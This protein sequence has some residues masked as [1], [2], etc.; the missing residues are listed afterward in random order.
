MQRGQS[1]DVAFSMLL[2]PALA[3]MRGVEPDYRRDLDGP[4][5][6]TESSSFCTVSSSSTIWGPGALA[7]KFLKAVGERSLDLVVSMIIR[8]KLASIK[9][10][11]HKS[12]H[13]LRNPSTVEE[14]QRMDQ[15]LSDL[16]ELCG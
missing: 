9:Q 5:S 16:K 15:I 4:S 12:P 3:E 7:G 10:T 1:I 2:P 14:W 6:F 8:R 11:L 13:V